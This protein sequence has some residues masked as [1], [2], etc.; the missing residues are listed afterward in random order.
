[1]FITGLETDVEQLRQNWKSSL[2]VALGGIILPF[3]GGY[4]AAL[5]FGLSFNQSIF[6]GLL[7]CATSVSI[8]VQTLKEMNQLSI[9]EGTTILGAAVIDDIVV[10]VLLAVMM[11][12]LGAGTDASIGLV[13]G[14]KVLFFAII[15]LAGWLLVPRIMKWLSPL[16]VTEAVISAALIICFLFVYFAEYM[17]V[18]GI[19]GSFAAGIAISQ[20]RFKHEVEEMV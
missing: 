15:W 13:I 4:G 14:K 6:F 16:Q 20:T 10:V 19:I 1:M 8:S 2:A 17:G 5:A 9:R 18:A 12:F 3:I 11:S 7:L